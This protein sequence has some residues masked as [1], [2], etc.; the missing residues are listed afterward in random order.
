MGWGLIDWNSPDIQNA[1]Y[2]YAAIKEIKIE[3]YDPPN[4][5][6]TSGSKAYIYNDKAGLN[7]TVEITNDNT[8]LK[9]FLGSGLQPDAGAQPSGTASASAAVASTDAPTVPGLSGAGTG[10]TGQRGGGGAQVEDSPN[11]G[12]PTPGSEG[13]SPTGEASAPSGSDFH[14]FS[15]GGS[16]TGSASNPKGEKVMQGSMLAVLL[17]IAGLLII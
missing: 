11:G 6:E 13:G 16:N 10:S 3:C 5:A 7:N 9:S 12:S 4:G 1:R 14:G 17:A 15:Q 8:I 2:Y